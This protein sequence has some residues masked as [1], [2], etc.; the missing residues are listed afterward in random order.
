VSG[1]APLVYLIVS[2][3]S[4]CSFWEIRINYLSRGKSRIR[5]DLPAA[6]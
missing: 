6:C 4:F 5:M 2:D 3:P 1:G